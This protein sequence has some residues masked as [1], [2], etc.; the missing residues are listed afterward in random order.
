MQQLIENLKNGK[1]QLVE[2]PVPSCGSQEI[3]VKN[4]ASLKGVRCAELTFGERIVVVG[5]GLIGLLLVQ[6]GKAYGCTVIGIDVDAEKSRLAVSLGCD[7][8]VGHAAN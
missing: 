8:G 7:L 2:T 3:L 4:V 5:L 1:V 6:L